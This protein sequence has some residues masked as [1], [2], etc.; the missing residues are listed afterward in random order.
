MRVKYNLD[1]AVTL[2]VTGP[3]DRG[4]A[5][6]LHNAMYGYANLNAV[7]LHVGV[8]KGR[9]R[10]VT[11]AVR[12]LGLCGF[13]LGEPHK[14]DIIELLDEVEPMSRAFRCVNTV[15]NR[16]GRLYGEGM[17]GVGMRMAIEQ[18]AGPV[19]GRHV[20]IIGAGAVGGL[21]PAD[22]CRHG[23]A[24]V[25]IANRTPSKAQFIAETLHAHF[26]VPVRFGGLEPGFLEHA[27]AQ[28]DLLVQCSSVGNPSHPELRRAGWPLCPARGCFIASSWRSC[29]C[30]LAWSC[31]RTACGR[32]AKR[33]RLRWRCG[34]FGE[35]GQASLAGWPVESGH[36]VGG[37]HDWRSTSSGARIWL[38]GPDCGSFRISSRSRAACSPVCWANWETVVS[39]GYTLMEMGE[40]LKPMTESACGMGMPCSCAARY[41]PTAIWSP[42]AKIAVGRSE[43]ANRRHGHG[44][45]VG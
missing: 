41:T 3:S 19:R 40:P 27:A 9:L 16:G 22:L 23:A 32:A 39:G 6:M 2:Q 5:C 45:A 17:D 29:S 36:R 4:A 26:G 28:A 30:V 1:T 38:R 7:D 44:H 43:R 31:R 8:E 14:S 24:S 13:S 42:A 34:R 20:L 12:G 15:V 18:K 35:C 33:L 25:T 10:C 21:I 11:D 37:A